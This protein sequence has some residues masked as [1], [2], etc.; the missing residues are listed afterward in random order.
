MNLAEI[1]RDPNSKYFLV[2]VTVAILGVLAKERF[3]NRI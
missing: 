3:P 1:F 2:P